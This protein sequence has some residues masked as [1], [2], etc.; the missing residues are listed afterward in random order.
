MNSCG[1]FGHYPLFFIYVIAI[2]PLEMYHFLYDLAFEGTTLWKLL[3]R[4]SP[5]SRWHK[6]L[7]RVVQKELLWE[8][9][10]C[11]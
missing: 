5:I 3:E 8:V 10:L 2:P 7:S 1:T 9:L 11:E 6:E 4:F